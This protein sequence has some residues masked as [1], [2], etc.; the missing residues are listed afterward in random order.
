V[1]AVSLA[2]G[3]VRWRRDVAGGVVSP[4]AIHG[5]LAVFTA[6]DGKVCG[7]DLSSGHE[8]WSY[9][10][11]QAFFAA[12]AVAGDTVFV[13]DLKSTVHAIGLADGRP[14]WTLEVA[15]DP[16]VAGPGAVFGSPI[17]HRGRL[18]LATCNLNA[19]SRAATV[20]VCIGEQ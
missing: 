3:A 17:V 4:V 14:R 19:E 20:V 12:P 10:A 18:Y 6:T 11:G 7:W 5:G 16:Q 13:A 9:N 8:K 1:L 2:D 15:S